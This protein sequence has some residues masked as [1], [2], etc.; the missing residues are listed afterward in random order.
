MN[1]SEPFIR[2]PVMTMLCMLSIVLAGLIGYRLL[3]VSDLPAV[4]FPTISVSASL[5]G[6]NP[7][8]MASTVATPLEKEFTTIAGLDSM[9]STSSQGSTR[10]TLQFDLNRNI[11][12]A[13]QDVQSAISRASRRLPEDLPTPPSF[14]KVNPADQPI[15]YLALTSPTLP[16][17]LLNEYGETQLAQ[18]ISRV[19]GVAQVSVYGSQ[20]YAVRIELDPHALASR[21]IGIDEVSSVIG[22]YNVNN[23]LGTLTGAQTLATLQSENQLMKAGLYLPLVVAYRDGQPVRLQELGNVRDSVENDRVAAWFATPTTRSRAIILAIQRQPGTNTIQVADAIKA[24]LPAFREKLPASVSLVVLRDSSIPIK[25]SARDVQF[26]LYLTLVLVVL[27][28]FLFLRNLSATVIPSLT[29]P[30]SLIGTFAVMYLLDYSIDNLSLMALTLSV[31]FVVDDAIVMLENI[32]R[33]IEM[34][35]PRMQAALEGAREIGFTIVS[36]TLSLAAVF[37]PV[38]FM[39]GIVG[40]LFREFSITIAV[41]V[42]IS[43]FVSLSLTPML[44]SRF[45][46]APG[47]E[48][49]GRVYLMVESGFDAMLS[50]YRSTLLWVLSRERAT[51]IF[52]AALL[53]ATVF[54]FYAIPKGFIPSEDRDQISIRTEAAENI[55]FDSM[56]Q[57]QLALLDIV[58]KDPN[59][60]RFMCSVASGGG[61]SATNTGS[62]FIVLKPRRERELSADQVIDRLRPKLA[63]VP[64]IRAFPTNPPP[65]N[66]GGRVT[67][68]LYQVT[69]Q[70]IETKELFRYGA[71]MEDRMRR[72][73]EL[74]DVSSDLQLKNPEVHIDIDRD[75]AFILN[76]TPMQ[77]E[78]ALYSAYGSRQI[79]T[80]YT[81][82]NDYQVIM[83]LLPQYRTDPSVLSM[84]HVRSS[85]GQLVPLRAITTLR[86]D[87]GPLTIS[88]S[89]QLPSVTISFNLK[90]GYSLGQAVERI[91]AMTA[92]SMPSGMTFEFQG[93]AKAFQ[94]SLASM[95]ILLILAIVVIYIILGILYESFYH[96]VTILSALPFAGFGALLALMAFRHDLSIYAFVGIVMLVGLVKKNGIMMV[97]FAIEAQRRQGKNPHDAVYE[98]CLVRFRPIMMTT[99]AA[100]MAGLPIALGYGAGAESRRPL[101]LAVV[102]GLLFSQ[103]LT[104]YVTPVFYVAMEKLRSRIASGHRKQDSATGAEP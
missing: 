12:A 32:M 103:T 78:N 60:D 99:M 28:I 101:G 52:S 100:L 93:T 88:H 85:T 5:P 13:A 27:V 94:S 59:V 66:I 51:L 24:L 71:E 44:A 2:R 15:L 70:G 30:V 56:V 102:G 22:H 42:L 90:P 98:A 11:D 67:K 82:N 80:I 16:M 37:I 61:Q 84:L 86:E 10:I 55:S 19:T 34:G 75:Q 21:G 69:F 9:I 65:I 54:L 8:T 96:P 95:G 14:R 74:Q 63:S 53:A 104:L 36:M 50:F 89:G 77:I 62:M 38:L 81:P 29:L 97:D 57:H 83:E 6:A 72:M 25:D 91:Q 76:V 92:A 47:R 45:I 43:G 68:S 40:R 35:K 20:K 23:P 1:L 49:H 3:P 58:Q 31:G 26:T 4:D 48:R 79:S 18:Q 64:G 73:E 39:G 33:H 87:I 46:R 17:Y 7:E 41:A